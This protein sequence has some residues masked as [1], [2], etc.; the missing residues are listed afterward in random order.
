MEG[1]KTGRKNIA[2]VGGREVS[3]ALGFAT[4]NSQSARLSILNG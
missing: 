1:R 2:L 3:N 4:R